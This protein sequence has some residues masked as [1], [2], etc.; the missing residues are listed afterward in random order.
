MPVDVELPNREN[1]T[2]IVDGIIGTEVLDRFEWWFDGDGT[3]TYF[4]AHS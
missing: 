2:T 3:T 4:R 1:I